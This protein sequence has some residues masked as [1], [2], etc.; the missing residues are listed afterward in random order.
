[1]FTIFTVIYIYIYIYIYICDRLDGPP[2][3]LVLK[4]PYKE[5]GRSKSALLHIANV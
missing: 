1:M 3:D 5:A 4:M 2:A